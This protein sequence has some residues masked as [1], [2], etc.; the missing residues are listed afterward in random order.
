MCV[1]L[2]HKPNGV[3]IMNRRPRRSGFLNATPGVSNTKKVM[4]RLYLIP[5]PRLGRKPGHKI[6][7]GGSTNIC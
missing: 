5:R 4:R 7:F 1:V 3:S 2:N 6:H